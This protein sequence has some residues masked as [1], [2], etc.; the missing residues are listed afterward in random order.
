MFG[1]GCFIATA[2]YG[3]QLH[4]YVRILREFRDS[5]LMPSKYG[6]KLVK[7]YYKYSPF[8]ADLI[9]R[10]KVLK[11]MV[12]FGLLPVI[13]FSYS[14]VHLGPVIAAVILGFIFVL[15]IL[16]VLFYRRN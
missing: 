14:M 10:H 6:S 11:V 15:P 3:S 7:L 8:F 9:A 13:V 1:G 12:R 4:P 2:A 5:Y 16:F